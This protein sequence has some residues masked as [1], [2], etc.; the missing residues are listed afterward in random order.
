MNRIGVILIATGRYKQFVAPLVAQCEQYFCPGVD[1]EYCLFHDE[2]KP[3]FEAQQISFP[4]AHLPW[5][6]PTLMRY[7]YITRNAKLFRDIF[8][9]LFY[10]DVDMALHAPA[11]FDALFGDGLTLTQHP[12]FHSAP[13]SALPYCINPASKAFFRRDHVLTTPR[14]YA[15]G[16]QGGTVESYLA[17]A[18]M[19]AAWCAEDLKN[20]VIPEWHDESYLNRYAAEIAPAKVLSPSYCWHAC[21]GGNFPK[22]IEALDKP[23]GWCREHNPQ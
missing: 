15:G 6:L 8:S 13:L 22:I 12:G 11:E 17:L 16:V 19:C 14:Y 5:P 4:V 21:A 10:L 18:Q 23:H 20:H 2:L 3:L 7:Q 9:H 1:K